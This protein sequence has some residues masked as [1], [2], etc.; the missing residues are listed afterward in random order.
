MGSEALCWLRTFSCCSLCLEC[1]SPRYLF[2]PSSLIFFSLSSNATCPLRPS[3]CL[4]LFLASF[5][6]LSS[7]ISPPPYPFHFFSLDLSS[8]HVLVCLFYMLIACIPQVATQ[9]APRGLWLLY[10]LIIAEPQCWNSAQ[11]LIDSLPDEDFL[12]EWIN[13]SLQT[14]LKAYTLTWDC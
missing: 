4:L 2:P 14:G 3:R 8:P 9:E 7:S 6:P 11:H 5:S 13:P 12:S 1:C 10:L